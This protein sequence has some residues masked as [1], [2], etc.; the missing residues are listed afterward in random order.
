M[1]MAER[2]TALSPETQCRIRA[3][4]YGQCVGDAIGLLTE[5]LTKEEAKKYYKTVK[6]TL[7]YKHK[8][9][10]C[11]LHRNRWKEGDWTD[12]SDQM[13]LILLSITDNNGVVI[14]K[15]VARRLKD[16]MREGIPELG[17][18]GGLGIG[19]TTHTVLHHKNYLE[20][21]HGTSEYVW[22]ESQCNIAPNG[23]VMRT[24][25][26]GVHQ[27]ED[28]EQVAKNASDIARITH[29]DHRCQASAVAVS[30]TIAMMLQRNKRHLDR[31]GHYHINLLIQEAYDIA[32]RYI[33][34]E[35]QK[36]ELLTYMKCSDIKWL[37]LAEAGK[38]GY[39][40]KSLGSGFWALKQNDFRKAIT[41]IVMEGGDAD[42]NACVAGALLACKLGL[43]AIPSS[44]R[45]TLLHKEWLDQQISR[46]FTL[47]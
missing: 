15:D 36:Q 20:D 37:K 6:K 12:D 8:A 34:K 14:Y 5:F 39:T 43:E 18:S 13:L 42:T 9:I 32:V 3:V 28:L 27:F 25:V 38:I 19:R 7:E 44:W 23:A 46:Y 17:D 22:R 33:V 16:W 11:D 24:S 10:V 2:S 30:V 35:E 31:K 47:M 1:S 4:L 45:D 26:V 21:P 40:F 41:K 29:H